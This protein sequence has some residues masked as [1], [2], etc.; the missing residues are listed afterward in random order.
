MADNRN[1]SDYQGYSILG[2]ALDVR[3][4]LGEELFHRIYYGG[5]LRDLTHEEA[6]A[7]EDLLVQIKRKARST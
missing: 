2:L 4:H 1:I 7:I 3:K 5:S 6:D